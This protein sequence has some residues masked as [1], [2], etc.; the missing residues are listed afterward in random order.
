[1]YR[2]WLKPR[3]YLLC[4][5]AAPAVYLVCR[6]LDRTRETPPAV[7][8]GRP[9]IAPTIIADPCPGDGVPSG[10]PRVEEETLPAP[11]DEPKPRP[12]PPPTLPPELDKPAP[13]PRYQPRPRPRPRPAPA[14]VDRGS[15]DDYAEALAKAERI[16]KRAEE[17]EARE[18]E[19][20]L[21]R[22][23]DRVRELERELDR[24]ERIIEDAK[25]AISEERRRPA[26][27]NEQRRAQSGRIDAHAQTRSDATKERSRLMQEL[28]GARRDL[29]GR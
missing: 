6:G 17:R 9:A 4:L 28:R 18:R 26:R 14:T 12:V 25:R 13:K 27:S 8:D 15:V 24:Q 21:E 5:L 20:E 7:A 19:R 29:E 11:T 10:P 3:H 2:P 1:M 16:R 23:R 22:K